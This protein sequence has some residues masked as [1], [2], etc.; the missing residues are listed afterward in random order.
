MCFCLKKK[1]INNY[2]LHR[3]KEVSE[4]DFQKDFWM[5][6]IG[7]VISQLMYSTCHFLP[8]ILF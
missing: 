5:A 7:L 4:N 1:K 3:K 8:I 6:A 2:K